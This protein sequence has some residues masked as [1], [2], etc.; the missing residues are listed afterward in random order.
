M[1]DYPESF[2]HMLAGW[3]E[4]DPA[5]IRAHLDR[6]LA[7]EVLF[8]DPT[9]VTRG[10]DEFEANVREFRSRWPDAVCARTSAFDTHHRLYRYSWQITRG[11]KVVVRGLDVVELDAEQRVQKVLGFFGPLQERT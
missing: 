7:D 10:R 11:E 2:D 4:A 9:I 1:S 5:K 8:V 3:N 6:A